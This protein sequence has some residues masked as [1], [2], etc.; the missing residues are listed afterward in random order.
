[1]LL[2]ARRGSI[3]WEI[4]KPLPISSARNQEEPPG[5]SDP[6]ESRNE[7]C[8]LLTSSAAGSPPR[9]PTDLSEGQRR[10]AVLKT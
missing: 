9:H 2:T 7:Q 6:T 10:R 4:A 8:T 1:M 5:S 3:S